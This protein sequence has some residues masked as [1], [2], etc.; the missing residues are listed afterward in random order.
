MRRARRTV[1]GVAAPAPRD[2]GSPAAR[3]PLRVLYALT[4][5]GPVP[6]RCR[7]YRARPTA[8]GRC[9]PLLYLITVAAYA[10]ATL[11]RRRDGDVCGR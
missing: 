11:A 2:S 5:V 4:L 9:C 6:P 8:P 1:A 10:L 7:G 3:S